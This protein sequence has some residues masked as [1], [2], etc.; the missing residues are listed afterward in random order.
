MAARVVVLLPWEAEG[1][2][3]VVMRERETTTVEEESA[4]VITERIT[5]AITATTAAVIP[6]HQEVFN[7]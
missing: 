7:L 6:V 3:P 5:T 2:R 4:V 1:P